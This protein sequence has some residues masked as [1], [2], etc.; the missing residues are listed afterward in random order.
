MANPGLFREPIKELEVEAKRRRQGK[1]Q[2]EWSWKGKYFLL[3]QKEVIY[4]LKIVNFEY[5]VTRQS[6][7][8]PHRTARCVPAEFW[9]LQGGHVGGALGKSL[10]A[11]PSGGGVLRWGLAKAVTK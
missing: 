11:A 3:N 6:A 7:C 5:Y 10:K 2:R 4:M 1:E 8:S 9:F